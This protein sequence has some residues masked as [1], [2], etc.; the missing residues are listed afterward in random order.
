LRKLQP[1]FGQA[2]PESLIGGFYSRRRK[3]AAFL[4]L[5]TKAHTKK[6]KEAD[7]TKFKEA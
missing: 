3:L 2:Q 7:T 1:I 4:S 5:L 6:L